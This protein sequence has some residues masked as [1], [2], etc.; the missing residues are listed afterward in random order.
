MTEAK[1][2]HR[3]TKRQ[4][5]RKAVVGGGTVM[6]VASDYLKPELETLLGTQVAQAR[7][8]GNHGGPPYGRGRGRGPRN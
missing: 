1:K 8:S 3:L 6:F 7:G 5:L 4:F 2:A